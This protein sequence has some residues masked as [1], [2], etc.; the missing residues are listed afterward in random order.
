MPK[1]FF[2][3]LEHQIPDEIRIA[4]DQCHPQAEEMVRVWMDWEAELC[5]QR[6][7]DPFVSASQPGHAAEKFATKG[8]FSGKFSYVVMHVDN[9]EGDPRR[10]YRIVV[11]PS[12]VWKFKNPCNTPLIPGPDHDPD[13]F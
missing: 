13:R 12:T 10:L 5:R 8:Q 2:V 7:E 9:E 4:I 1:T 11:E 6:G 3:C